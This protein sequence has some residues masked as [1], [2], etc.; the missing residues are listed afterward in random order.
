M[1]DMDVAIRRLVT[2]LPNFGALQQPQAASSM[3]T[4]KPEVAMEAS[5]DLQPQLPKILCT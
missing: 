2:R 1:R 3:L 5:N 4:V